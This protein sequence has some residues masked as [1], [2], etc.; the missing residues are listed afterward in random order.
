MP[1]FL[2]CLLLTSV[3]PVSLSSECYLPDTSVSKY[4]CRTKLSMYFLFP[5]AML[6]TCPAYIGLLHFITCIVCIN[7]VCACVIHSWASNKNVPRC[8]QVPLPKFKINFDVFSH[9]IK[10][11]IFVLIKTKKLFEAQVFFLVVRSDIFKCIF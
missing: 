2:M 4:I 8:V 3:V 9:G 10:R 11:P 5:Q 6:K 1:M 7:L